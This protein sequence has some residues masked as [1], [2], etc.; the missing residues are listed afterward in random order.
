MK[1]SLFMCGSMGVCVC[2]CV[3]VCVRVYV[4]V[5]FLGVALLRKSPFSLFILRDFKISF[6]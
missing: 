1:I 5:F 4:Y 6:S 3:C 2:V